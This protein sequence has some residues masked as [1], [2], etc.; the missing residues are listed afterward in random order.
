MPNKIKNGLMYLNIVPNMV[1]MKLRHVI[2]EC[3]YDF[4]SDS[5]MQRLFCKSIELKLTG[6]LKEYPYGV[7]P[8]DTSDFVATHHLVCDDD[9]GVFNPVMCWKSI[10]LARC[11]IHNLVLPPL[12]GLRTIVAPEHTGAVEAI[13]GRHSSKASKLTYGGGLTIHPEARKDR[14]LVTQ[15]WEMMMAGTLSYDLEYG[16]AETLCFGAVRFKMERV[17]L[18]M[19]YRDLEWDGRALGA[20]SMP[21]QMNGFEAR[22]FHR[23]EF[24]KAALDLVEKYRFWWN[25][26]IEIKAQAL[27][28]Q[29]SER[30]GK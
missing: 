19:G 12:A 3:P 16:V 7:L 28:A 30:R 11:K 18:G 9:K 13:V 2:L 14:Q 17:F 5:E 22:L 25:A 29:M 26:R 15:L 20:V 23:T 4:W 6:Y 21:T 10:S 27:P 1:H 24:T 8:F